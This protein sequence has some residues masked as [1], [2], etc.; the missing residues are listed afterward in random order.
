MYYYIRRILALI[1]T[2]VLVSMVVFVLFQIIPGDPVLNIL[3]LEADEHQIAALREELGTDLPVH[4]R[5]INWAKGMLRGDAGNSM[6]FGSPVTDLIKSRLPVTLSLTIMSLGIAIL[7]AI[8]LGIIAARNSGK[9]SDFI[10]SIITQLGMAVPSFWLGIILLLVFG[11]KLKWIRPGV[12][13]P[14][15]ESIPG[16]FKSLLL[17]SIAIA[18]PAI[19]TIVRYLRTTVI[20]Q[21]KLDYVRTAYSKGLAKNN[22]VYSHVLKNALIPVV[23]V[24]GMITASILGGSLIIEQVFALPGIGRLFISSIS[25]RDY[26]LVQG[27]VMYIATAIILINLI[28]DV[29]YKFLD[30]RIKLK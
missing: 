24:M 29:I 7:V 2:L 25:F 18:I 1:I 21:L 10:I 26:Y 27:M 6:R 12:Y 5:Y 14:W 13:I 20:E 8:P 15:N 22:I 4:I 19:A 3:G 16:A 17:P 11:V 23:T 9:W 28:V 30:P